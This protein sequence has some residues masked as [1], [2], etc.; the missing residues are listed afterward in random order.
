[1]KAVILS[2]K[3]KDS[4]FPFCETKPTGMIPVGGEPLV[5]R[6]IN[7]LQEVGVDD[8]YLVV[9]HFEEQFENEFDEYTNVNT[10]HQ[11]ELTGTAEAVNTA[12]FIQDDFVV[13]NGDVVVE[14]SDIRKL[15]ESHE[16]NSAKAT[17]LGTDQEK[18]EKF[19]VLRIKNDEIIEV[20]EKPEEPES[21]L[22]NTGIYIFDPVIFDY[23]EDLNED[24]TSI[25]DGLNKLLE[26][27][28]ARFELVDG[29]WIDIGSLRK[30][31]EADFQVRN[32]YE[33][34][35]DEEADISDKAEIS[36]SAVIRKN[37]EI[38]AGAVIEGNTYIG[39]NAKIGPNTTVR[40]ST[41]CRN[42]LLDNCVIDTSLL[43]ERNII[44]PNTSIEKCVL[45]E[46]TDVKAST[47]IRESF[48]GAE[49]FIE[50]NN[51]IYGTKFVPEARTDLSEI[52]K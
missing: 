31:L 43:F 23:I 4:L 29:N 40:D 38:K 19:G 36:D 46:K 15:I 47:V 49:S 33:G 32:D 52:S 45:G 25:T 10:I 51:S 12:D 34:Y 50:M 13:I 42:A 20:Q 11:E 17:V 24:Q 26:H 14:E 44:D 3:K 41:I 8:V 1:M 18:P 30:L 48:I 9:N 27:Y 6:M 21:P 28:R 22:I 7:Q 37:V 16:S 35:I 39:K 2:A 5:K